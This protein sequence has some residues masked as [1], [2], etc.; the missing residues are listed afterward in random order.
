MKKG[1]RSTEQIIRILRASEGMKVEETDGP[2]IAGKS[3][4]ATW[5]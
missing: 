4:M 1:R 5:A 2:I 3:N